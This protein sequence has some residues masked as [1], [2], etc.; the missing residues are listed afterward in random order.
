M[1][2]HTWSRNFS[3][4]KRMLPARSQPTPPPITQQVGTKQTDIQFQPKCMVMCVPDLLF[5]CLSNILGLSGVFETSL[6][7]SGSNTTETSVMNFLPTIESRSLQA[8]PATASL[9]PQFRTPSWQ[10][11]R[12]TKIEVSVDLYLLMCFVDYCAL[13]RTLFSFL[14]KY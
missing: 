9:L 5:L 10:T 4:G 13:T 6:H 8:G 1:V 3:S 7:S 12:L 2:A 14:L 11:G